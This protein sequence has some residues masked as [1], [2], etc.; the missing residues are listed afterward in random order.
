MEA[1]WGTCAQLSAESWQGCTPIVENMLRRNEPF[2]KLSREYLEKYGMIY[3][4]EADSNDG[5][6][7]RETKELKMFASGFSS[8]TV[9]W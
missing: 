7:R 3:R 4:V 6:S 5:G 9:T 2:G 1:E 8:N